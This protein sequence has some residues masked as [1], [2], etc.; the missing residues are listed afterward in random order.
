MLAQRSIRVG[1]FEMYWFYHQNRFCSIFKWMNP[2]G[3]ENR[4]FLASM[5]MNWFNECDKK[6]VLFTLRGKCS[7]SNEYNRQCVFWFSLSLSVRIQYSIEKYSSQCC[8]FHSVSL[9]LQSKSLPMTTAFIE[10]VL[11]SRY[12]IRAYVVFCF[13]L[14][15][16]FWII[17]SVFAVW[18]FVILIFSF[19]I[20][21]S[22][23]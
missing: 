13:N 5:Q 19:F 20:I 1:V 14:N 8:F 9:S 12:A 11:R 22:Q 10:C 2:T 17:G 6:T 16:N 18:I 7:K 15:R 4:P 23:Q 3:L 21:F